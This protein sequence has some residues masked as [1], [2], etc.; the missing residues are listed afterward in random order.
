M[1]EAG[2]TRFSSW[3]LCWLWSLILRH[4][5][6]DVEGMG[7]DYIR[8]GA[9]QRTSR[10]REKRLSSVAA[11]DHTSQPHIKV[12]SITPAIQLIEGH[13]HSPSVDLALII[14]NLCH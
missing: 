4:D 1:G 6:I 12:L 10:D 11:Y 3:S 5:R 8:G 13:K 9:Y 7:Q 2:T 14:A